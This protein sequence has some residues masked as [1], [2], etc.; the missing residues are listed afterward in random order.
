MKVLIYS[1]NYA[2]ELT[3]VGKYSGELADWLSEH[4]HEVRVVASPPYYPDWS[5]DDGY[6][7]WA[8]K[9]EQDSLSLVMRCPLWVPKSPN[10]IKRILHLISFAVTSFPIML[11]WS[12]WKADVVI[13]IEPPLFCSPAA[14]MSGFLGNS[15][16]ILHVQ[17][18]EVDAAFDLGLVKGVWLKNFI[19]WGEQW[20]YRHFDRVTTISSNMLLL[21]GKKGVS[22]SNRFLFPNWV[23]T[24][25][26]FPTNTKSSFRADLCID[27]NKIVALYSGNMGEKQGLDIIID[28]ASLLKSNSEI[29]FVMCGSGAAYNRL[30]EIGIE[31]TNI[32]WL[33]LQPIERLNELLN[34]ADI[35]LLPQ[36]KDVAD[37]VM[38]SKLTG[39]LASGKPVLATAESDTEIWEMVKECGITTVS[40]GDTSSFA[41]AIVSL[42]S[43][44][45]LRSRLGAAARKYAEKYLDQEIVL[46]N[47]EQELI[48]LLKK[49]NT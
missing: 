24:Q 1:L 6:N 30:K 20:L 44:R 38:P 41:E 22:E 5:V 34:I 13:V 25:R 17:D 42:A 48:S 9:K 27:S 39:M 3:G 18:F 19:Q 47:F 35:H 31:L 16:T 2:P 10:G 11:A 49:E 12:F 32:Y 7:P 37:L 45:E 28:A 33:P 21:L 4:N 23:N 15:K 26:I 14:L 40:S 36:R 8:Y 43:D 29:V 46:S